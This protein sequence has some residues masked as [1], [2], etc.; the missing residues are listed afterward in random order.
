MANSGSGGRKRKA[1]A[2]GWEVGHYAFAYWEAD[3]YWY[4]AV[5][6]AVDGDEI[7]V[8]YDDGTTE[9]TDTA[10][11]IDVTVSVGDEVECWSDDD[12]DYYEAVV[13]AV[14]GD[15]IQVTYDEDGSKETVDLSYLRWW[16]YWGEGDRVFAYWEED[17]YWYP[18]TI[19]STDDDGIYVIWDYEDESDDTALS[20]DSVD[21]LQVWVGDDVEAWWEEDEQYYP[22]KVIA[23]NGDQVQVEYEDGT[24][25]VDITYL[26][27]ADE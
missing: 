22:A 16:G 24:A 26:R 9:T 10:S 3:E 8:E 21:E 19:D 14:N 25:W 13:S 15:D 4:P 20:E 11:V 5:I 12:E 27:L 6:K 1:N 18:A 7:T 17:G 2:A 23:V